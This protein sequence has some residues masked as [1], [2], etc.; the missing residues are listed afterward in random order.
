MQ[1]MFSL[2]LR[3]TLHGTLD[4]TLHGNLFSEP[5]ILFFI[6]FLRPHPGPERL[7]PQNHFSS[8]FHR[9]F[10]LVAGWWRC[11]GLEFPP[12]GCLKALEEQLDA[13]RGCWGKKVPRLEPT[14]RSATPQQRYDPAEEEK[15]DAGSRV[16]S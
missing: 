15:G 5:L 8:H 12:P 14:I 10:K 11:L 4:G 2:T 13:I 6:S 16:F 9:S 7:R 3:G 1:F